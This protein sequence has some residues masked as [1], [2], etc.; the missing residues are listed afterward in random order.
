MAGRGGKKFSMND[1][2][3][4]RYGMDEYGQRLCTIVIVILIISVIIN[5]ASKAVGSW[6]MYV[7]SAINFVGLAL[8]VYAV[9]RS[10]SRNI[11]KRSAENEHFLER[12]RNSK[13]ANRGSNRANNAGNARGGFGGFG[14]RN[15]NASRQAADIDQYKYLCCSFC[16]QK[17]RVPRGRGKVAVTCPSCGE[18][19]IVDSGEKPG[20]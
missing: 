2:M 11:S 14:K 18:K 6:L 17:M 16:D 5:F 12:S 10:L 1:F 3:R 19:T 13:R 4:G 8:A 20:A 9:Y 15:A 7:G